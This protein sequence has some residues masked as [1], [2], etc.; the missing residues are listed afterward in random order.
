MRHREGENEEGDRGEGDEEEEG[1]ER[2]EHLDLGLSSSS[3]MP[4]VSPDSAAT[5][6]L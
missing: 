1:M 2:D 6:M 3:S 4:K 5:A